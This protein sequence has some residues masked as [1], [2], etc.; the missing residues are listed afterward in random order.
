[1]TT[2]ASDKPHLPFTVPKRHVDKYPIESI[3]VATNSF[4]PW[5]L[6]LVAWST[7]GELRSYPDIQEVDNPSTATGWKTRG[8]P[9]PGPNA[10][11]PAGACLHTTYVLE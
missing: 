6:P 8:K 1:V 7:Y 4:A 10:S 3:Q 5:D 11:F 9:A 2:Y